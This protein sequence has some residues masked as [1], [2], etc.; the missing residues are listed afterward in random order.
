MVSRV[1]YLFL[2]IF[3]VFLL[4]GHTFK[5]YLIDFNSRKVYFSLFSFI[6][7]PLLSFSDIGGIDK[8]L[9]DTFDHDHY[10]YKI[11]RRG[12]RF[13]NGIPLTD[14]RNVCDESNDEFEK[15]IAKN[16]IPFIQYKIG[17]SG[18]LLTPVAVNPVVDTFA[19]GE[20]ECEN[21]CFFEDAGKLYFKH[22]LNLTDWLLVFLL[23]APLFFIV[24]GLMR[25][26]SIIVIYIFCSAY[27]K[28]LASKRF[29]IK[30]CELGT[31]IGFPSNNEEF[32]IGD[33]KAFLI[34]TNHRSFRGNIPFVSSIDISVRLYKKGIIRDELLERFG[35]GELYKAYI[36][37]DWLKYFFGEDIPL[38][39]ADNF[40]DR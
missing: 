30:T 15:F 3:L 6:N 12:H 8:S 35:T 1:I 32:T 9:V 2:G 26:L 4:K 38:K 17:N 19:A 10:F 27:K 25:W 11:W 24:I 18:D 5:R 31:S 37:F 39:L 36:L 22:V 13:E 21:C 28:E 23:S 40:L 29:F 20:L 33:I 16:F 7:L 14:I 34:Q